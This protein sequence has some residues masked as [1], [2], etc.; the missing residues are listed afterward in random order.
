MTT[1][2]DCVICSKWPEKDRWALRQMTASLPLNDEPICD[3]CL[4][5]F[6]ERLFGPSEAPNS[7]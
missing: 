3:E 4:Q 7:H 6:L 1:E 5:V 2:N